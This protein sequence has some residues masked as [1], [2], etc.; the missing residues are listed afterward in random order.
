MI[1]LQKAV[2]SGDAFILEDGATVSRSELDRDIEELVE[3]LGD[4]E[5]VCCLCENE[6]WSIT[7]YLAVIQAGS[8]ALL[9]PNDIAEESLQRIANEY[10]PSFWIHSRDDLEEYFA[11]R[12]LWQRASCRLQ[13]SKVK[14]PVAMH[15]NL[16]LLLPTSGSTGSP[17]LV[18]MTKTNIE[19]NADAII[20]YLQ[21]SGSDRAVTTLPME[22]SYG[23]SVINS[24]LRAGASIAVT[25]RSIFDPEFWK[26]VR[27]NS[28]TSMAGVPYTYKML[29]KLNMG[30]LD[31]G[32]INTMTQAGGRLGVEHTKAVAEECAKRGIRYFTMYGQTEATARIAYL[33]SELT[34]TKPGSIG[35]PVPGGL[36]WVE[37]EEGNVIREPG[38]AGQLVY[39][40]RN[41]S[42]G[43]SQCRAD[44]SLGDENHGILKTGDLAMFDNDGYFTIVGR[45]SRYVK[46]FG[47][48]VSLDAIEE[49]LLCKGMD[50]VVTGQDDEIV[51]NLH[52]DARLDRGLLQTEMAKQLAVNYKA[53]KVVTHESIP[54]L[55]NGKVNYAALGLK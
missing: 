4:R 46:I 20:E 53:I 8:V 55:K 5:L 19:S 41:V 50:A 15:K 21:I 38:V 18:R 14:K 35:G 10:A 25:D 29:L 24:H 16:A 49:M 1:F 30:R 6:R 54:R 52:R 40:G 11:E 2:T 43:Y 17:K 51:I 45:L 13:R 36:L 42:M 27:K 33:P 32:E 26:F 23:L 48:R 7:A 39:S 9:L 44:L 31:L 12:V 22:Y 37:D 3:V 47:V 28:V 34:L